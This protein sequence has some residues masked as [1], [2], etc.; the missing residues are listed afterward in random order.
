MRELKHCKETLKSSCRRNKQKPG[1]GKNCKSGERRA[2]ENRIP[3][4]NKNQ[5][6]WKGQ[7]GKRN[8]G[9]VI[10]AEWEREREEI[11]ANRKETMKENSETNFT[12]QPWIQLWSWIGSQRGTVQKHSFPSSQL[13]A[14]PTHLCWQE[15]GGEWKR[16]FLSLWQSHYWGWM[17]FIEQR[18]SL[19]LWAF[20]EPS[21]MGQ[22]EKYNV[23]PTPVHM[24]SKSLVCTQ[25]FL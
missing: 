11:V 16:Q 3:G 12:G 1:D 14:H 9:T 25:P 13:G 20:A 22:T 18:F 6:G 21:R 15:R 19:I 4:Q 10:K 24:A 17:N 8:H 7:E 2:V 5:E 23:S